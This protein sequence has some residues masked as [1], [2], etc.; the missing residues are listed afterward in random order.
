MRRA[1]HREIDA[2]DHIASRHDQDS[3]DRRPEGDAKRL[4]LWGK[5]ERHKTGDW[6]N[7][8]LRAQ[9]GKG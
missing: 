1:A 4:D 9:N 8:A 6:P 7:P 3:C 2:E 5:D